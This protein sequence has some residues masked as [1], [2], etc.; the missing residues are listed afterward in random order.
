MRKLKVTVFT[1]SALGIVA[2]LALANRYY[3]PTSNLIDQNAL[4]QISARNSTHKC[5]FDAKQ[6]N[7]WDL[8][9][10]SY[11]GGLGP[12]C[13]K[14]SDCSTSYGSWVGRWCTNGTQ[15]QSTCNDTAIDKS[16]NQNKVNIV[17]GQQEIVNGP[18]ASC[19]DGHCQITG[20]GMATPVPGAYCGQYSSCK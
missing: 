16:C 20:W 4:S 1:I 10:P 19:V 13:S 14:D 9:G 11:T 8:S 3:Q 17:C 2:S 12:V 5:K 6:C 7:W 15:N 18:N